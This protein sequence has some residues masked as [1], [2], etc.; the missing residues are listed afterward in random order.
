MSNLGKLQGSM[1]IARVGGNTQYGFT[2]VA[3]GNMR[4]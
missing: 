3:A 4:S 2:L 1:P